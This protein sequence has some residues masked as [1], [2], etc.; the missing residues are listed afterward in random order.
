[1][2]VRLLRSTGVSHGCDSRLGFQ[3]VPREP[4][5]WVGTHFLGLTDQGH[6]V[7]EGIDPVQPTGVYQTHEQIPHLGAPFGFVAERC[8]W[9]V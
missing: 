4:L 8:F 2:T 7:F 6:E 9:A 1:M 3:V 5:V